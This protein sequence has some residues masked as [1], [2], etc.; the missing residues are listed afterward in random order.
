MCDVGSMPV[1]MYTC[2][3]QLTPTI[4]VRIALQLYQAVVFLHT[5]SPPLDR[6]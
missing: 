4:K 6:S 1:S 5:N 3:I 2:T